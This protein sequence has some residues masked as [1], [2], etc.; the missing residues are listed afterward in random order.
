MSTKAPH[1]WTVHLELTCLSCRSR[2]QYLS[3]RLHAGLPGLEDL[4]VE[5]TPL[6]SAAIAILRRHRVSYFYEEAV[7]V[8]EI[9][10]PSSSY[11][12]WTRLRLPLPACD[13]GESGH[14]PLSLDSWTVLPRTE[15]NCLY[16][17]KFNFKSDFSASGQSQ[18][19]FS[20]GVCGQGKHPAP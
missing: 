13:E 8:D 12:A 15:L 4:G 11:A 14:D 18:R 1:I 7:D 16:I 6:E 19:L 10:R 3:D 20:L 9:C 5:P 2:Q 17:I